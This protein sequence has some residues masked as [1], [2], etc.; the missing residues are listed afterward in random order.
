MPS[1]RE[2]LQAAAALAALWP[3]AWS[4]AFA[5]Q[6]L[7]QDQLLQFAPLGNVTLV[8]IADLHAQLVPVFLREPAAHVA[9]TD[10]RRDPPHAGTAD[11]LGHF[12][13][14]RG[15]AAAHALTG[16]DFVALARAYGRIGGLDRIATIV[17]AIRAERG[18]RV[19][20]LD[21]GDTWQ[22]SYTSL[23][24]QGQDVVDCMTLLKPDAMVGHWEFT[25]GAERV[26]AITAQLGFPFL[27]QNIRDT[28][29]NEAA[30]E[31]MVM[32]ERGGIKIAVIGQAFPY[33]P[34]A[35]PRRMTPQWSFG[36]REET[37]Q[38]HVRT[39]RQAGAALVVLLS[40]NG[41]DVDLKLAAR[42][43]GLDVIL[44][45]HTHDAFPEAVK[46]GKTLL[47]ASGSHGKFVSRLDLDVRGGEVKD[48]RYKLI[49]VF[50]D[51]IAPDAAMER[52]VAAIRAPHQAYLR[53]VV[54][55]T[56]TV[57][58]RHGTFN[59]TLDNLICD[60]LRVELD[61]E[62]ALSPGF[63]W[64]ASLLGGQDITRED[65]YNATAISYPETYRI[66]M[67]GARIKDVLEDVCDNLLNPD[68]YYRQGGDMVRVGGLSYAL[69][70][71]KPFGSRI[72]DLRLARSGER[73]RAADEYTVAGWA[74]VN[75]EAAGAPI[76]DL[77]TRYIARTGTV[78]P[79]EESHV[80]LIGT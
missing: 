45:G 58:F 13:I 24:S 16:E 79:S 42:V 77:L 6:R 70:P 43:S 78:A 38:T 57:L 49:P 56:E 50:A 68:P 18:D 12:N 26:K 3:G 54:G 46:V 8:H 20:L 60:A 44:T 47:V 37:L 73:L 7:S 32:I 9:L 39:A 23:I 27:G 25:L 2:F 63:R 11:F 14:A 75:E 30:F 36:I 53:E 59:G 28:E 66:R 74:R 72:S 22:N 69:E 4:R 65:I 48:Y 5:Q 55:R 17:N 34:V 41:F 67:S 29:W 10:S 71:R 61:A 80:R 15:S 76:W 40:H 51:A 33:T 1:R 31:P 35:H 21:G 52:T 62:I 19:V 64:G